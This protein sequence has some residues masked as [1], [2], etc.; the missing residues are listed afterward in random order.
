MGIRKGVKAQ[1]HNGVRVYWE[2]TRV[3][4]DALKSFLVID[5]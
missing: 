5:T 3:E 1:R 4:R 2:T